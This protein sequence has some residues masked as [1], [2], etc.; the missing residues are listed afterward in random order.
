MNYTCLIGSLTC[1][2][3][4][5]ACVGADESPEDETG[6]AADELVGQAF[7]VSPKDKKP[8]HTVSV[9]A[10]DG[11]YSTPNWQSDAV[12]GFQASGGTSAW[13]FSSNTGASW[14]TPPQAW[15]VPAGLASDFNPWLRYEGM[16]TVLSFR[17]EQ[18]GVSQLRAVLY[19][20]KMAVPSMAQPSLAELPVNGRRCPAVRGRRSDVSAPFQSPVRR[21][22]IVPNASALSPRR[23][24]RIVTLRGQPSPLSGA[25][26]SRLA[27]PA[28]NYTKCACERV[29]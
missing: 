28:N 27:T 29:R 22:R 5:G 21:A 4:L 23:R 10:S 11:P 18:T 25:S 8:N 13:A 24:R 20:T 19:V 14:T 7:I 17:R 2:L 12:V 9:A 15:A 26:S 1:A 3:M 16:P 6:I